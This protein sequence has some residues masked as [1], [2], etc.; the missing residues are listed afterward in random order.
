MTFHKL[1]FF[2]FPNYQNRMLLAGG[3]DCVASP[4]S[5]NE[6]V[7]LKRTFAQIVSSLKWWKSRF[8]AN[9]IEV[10]IYMISCWQQTLKEQCQTTV[11]NVAQ[12][13]VRMLLQASQEDAE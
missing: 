13:F 10:T 1:L 12:S 5:N 11:E 7:L 4:N 6:T 3:F 8:L 2:K 9:T